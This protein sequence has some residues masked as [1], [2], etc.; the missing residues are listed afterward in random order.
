MEMPHLS[1]HYFPHIFN[2]NNLTITATEIYC[3]PKKSRVNFPSNGVTRFLFTFLQNTFISFLTFWVFSASPQNIFSLL[4]NKLL[5]RFQW[6]FFS[7]CVM[8]IHMC[9]DVSFY[10]NIFWRW[11]F[12]KKCLIPVRDNKSW[13]WAK[14]DIN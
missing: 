6:K 7:V 13:K 8:L 4:T 5:V 11:Y 14:I 1:P 3:T 10:T 2:Y 12:L 9:Q